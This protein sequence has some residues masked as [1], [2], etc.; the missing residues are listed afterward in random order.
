M[1]IRVR[2]NKCD[3]YDSSSIKIYYD[4]KNNENLREVIV[5]IL[6]IISKITHK[7]YKV[8]FD[9]ECD[10][11]CILELLEMNK[12]DNSIAN[13]FP[14]VIKEWHPT[15]NGTLK[16]EYISAHT[17]KKMWWIC[18]KGHEYQMVVKHK[19]EDNCACPICSNHRILSGYN[20]L[21]T[22]RPDIAKEFDYDKNKPLTPDKIAVSANYKVWWICPKGHSY[23]YSVAHR[24]YSGRNCPICSNRQLLQGYNDL[25]TINKKIADEWNYE[26]NVGLKPGNVLQGGG[27]K[28]YWWI[29]SCGH[30]WDSAISSRI[31][32]RQ[33]KSGKIKTI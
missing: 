24:T 26:K 13:L 14:D 7:N 8:D 28:K 21:K 22:L 5:K 18:P 2:E 3:R 6:K 20:D 4:E 29:G 25:V 23:Y 11:T 12:K 1:V 19:T 33:G 10:S 9:L 32:V 16:P 27:N 31:T 30:E 17:H 15:K